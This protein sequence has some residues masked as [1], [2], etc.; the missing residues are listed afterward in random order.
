M[1]KPCQSF[2]IHFWVDLPHVC[3]HSSCLAFLIHQLES[4]F[5]LPLTLSGFTF[6]IFLI[7]DI[8]HPRRSSLVCPRCLG[9]NHFILDS[10][11]LDLGPIEQ[12]DIRPRSPVQSSPLPPV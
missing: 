12:A 2:S 11:T 8:L 10:D 5:Y 3:D 4:Y 6:W 1:H 9:S 7:P